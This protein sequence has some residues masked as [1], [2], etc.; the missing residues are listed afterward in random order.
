M[1]GAGRAYNRQIQIPF[2]FDLAVS[3]H[4]LIAM[5]IL[6][7]AEIGIVAEFFGGATTWHVVRTRAGRW[8]G[9]PDCDAD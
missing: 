7:L 1:A 5:P 8:S 6:A 3:V 9:D 2:S 4:F